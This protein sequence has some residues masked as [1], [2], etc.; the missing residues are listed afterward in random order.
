MDVVPLAAA[1]LSHGYGL[2]PSLSF[3]SIALLGLAMTPLFPLLTSATPQYLGKQHATNGV[4]LQVAAAGLGGVLVTSLL[5]VLA[6]TF[7][8]AAIAPALV[9]SAAIIVLLFKLLAHHIVV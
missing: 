8:L 5:G 7:G 4:G 3:V 1:L 2:T 6:Q 9:V